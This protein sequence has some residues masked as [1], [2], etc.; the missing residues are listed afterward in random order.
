MVISATT[1]LITIVLQEYHDKIIRGHVGFLHTYKIINHD[2]YWSM[3]KKSV[4]LHAD[5]YPT[6]Q[7]QKVSSLSLVGLLQP[8]PILTRYGKISQWIRHYPYP[9]TT[10]V[11]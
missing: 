11:Y 6:Y 8:L 4:K 3:M 5:H 2:L 10:I 7:Q 1:S 9:M